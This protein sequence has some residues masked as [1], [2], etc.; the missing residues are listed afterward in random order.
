MTRIL[1]IAALVFAF[2]FSAYPQ[3]APAEDEILKIHAGLDSAFIKKDLAFFENVM[4]PDYV[5]SDPQGNALDRAGNIEQLKKE[6]GQAGYKM[7]SSDTQN[8]KVKIMGN[9]ALITA[10][11]TFTSQG[12]V[13]GAEPHLDKGRY[14]GVYEKRDGK[15]MLI[16]EHFSEAP[17]DRKLMEQQVMKAG[18]EYAQIIKNQD[19]AGIENILAE[20]YIYTDESGKV[21]N[22][23][24][25]IAGYKNGQTKFE[26]ADISDQ[27]VIITGNGSAVETGTFYVKG[28]NAGKAFDQT[29]RYTTT[30]VW[31]G[32]R[33]RVVADHVSVLKK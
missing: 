24:E 1:V 29:E 25:D 26:I 21:K 13:A 28:T 32:G 12:T 31:R 4:A 8:P 11:W 18:L 19:L 6:W 23:A 2:A 27:K 7:L 30:W 17:H 9:T 3:R 15:W 33:W 22:R 14:T 10:D 5:Y 16:A 20:E